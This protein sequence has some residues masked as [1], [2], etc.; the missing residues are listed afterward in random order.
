[1]S[2][3]GAD[4]GPPKPTCWG[5][6]ETKKALAGDRQGFR[7]FRFEI[8]IGSERCT[9]DAVISLGRERDV[10]LHHPVGTWCLAG[11]P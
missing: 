7:E 11:A 2:R 6:S 5:Q 4:L 3:W 8:E 9:T 10:N 1:M